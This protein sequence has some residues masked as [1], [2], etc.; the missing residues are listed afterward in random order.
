MYLQCINEQQLV[1]LTVQSL[2]PTPNDR[3][4]FTSNHHLETK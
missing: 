1:A 3:L 2:V 4:I